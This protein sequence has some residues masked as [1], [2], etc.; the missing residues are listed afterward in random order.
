MDFSGILLAGGKSK[1]FGP[2]KIK[3][4]SGDVPLLV[5]QVVKL[6]F[7]TGEVIVAAVA[8]TVNFVSLKFDIATGVGAFGIKCFEVSHVVAQNN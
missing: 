3:I 2:N 8:V 4:V 1:G 5:E 7:F 6:G